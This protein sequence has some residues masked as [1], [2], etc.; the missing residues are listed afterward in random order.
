MYAVWYTLSVCGVRPF[1]S[2]YTLLDVCVCETH[3]LAQ[4]S[5]SFHIWFVVLFHH[6]SKYRCKTMQ[7]VTSIHREIYLNKR[8]IFLHFSKQLANCFLYYFKD[9]L[10]ILGEII[11]IVYVSVIYNYKLKDSFKKPETIAKTAA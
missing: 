2:L 8:R 1:S 9:C 4:I 5:Y 11:L 3:T 7:I 10:E 6:S